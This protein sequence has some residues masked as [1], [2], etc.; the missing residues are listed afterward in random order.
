MMSGKNSLAWPVGDEHGSQGGKENRMAVQ[1]ELPVREQDGSGH[2]ADNG[3]GHAKDG[4]ARFDHIYNQPDPRPYFQTLE[5]FG[6][7]IPGHGQAMFTL[8]VAKLRE[9]RGRKDLT[10][11][12][13]CCSYGVN[14][15]LLNHELTLDALYQRYRSPVLAALSSQELAAADAE[16]YPQWRRESPLQVVGID[17]AEQAV[18]YAAR[19]GLLVEASHENLESKDPSERLSRRLR[20]V[21]LITV[22][23]GIGYISERT[24]ESVLSVTGGTP[25]VAA[26]ALRW[27]SF[28]PIAAVLDQHGLVTEKLTTKTFVQ[29]R[30]TGEAERTYVLE[31]LTRLGIDPTGKEEGGHYHADFY[32][33]RPAADVR[34]LPLEDLGADV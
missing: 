20:D 32:L 9:Q 33:S 34:S 25:W 3:N 16:F 14:A 15:A 23:G 31:E 13:L 30:F 1:R 22:T 7:E 4:K 2:T 26:F 5:E 10:V 18:G 8:L 11:L 12:D 24:F 17:T 27:V 6:Y 28:D 29:R 21:G 19:A